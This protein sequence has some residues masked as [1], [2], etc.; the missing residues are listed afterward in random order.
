MARELKKLFKKESVTTANGKKRSLIV[1]N[2]KRLR[3]C[4]ANTLD[5][6]DNL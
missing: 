2:P 4:T 5:L 6:A 1:D 3:I